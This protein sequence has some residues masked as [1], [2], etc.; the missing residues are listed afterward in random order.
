MSYRRMPRRALQVFA[1]LGA[2]SDES[3][4]AAIPVGDPYRKP[5]NYC[6]TPDGGYTTFNADGSVYVANAS[7]GGSFLDK[8]GAAIGGAL[9][10]PAVPAYPGAYPPVLPQTGMSTT[11][12]VLIAGAIVAAA[13]LASR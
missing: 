12:K 3:P 5:G 10:Q 13:V 9:G 4:C 6:A 11:T 7:S 1:G 2:Y 8:L